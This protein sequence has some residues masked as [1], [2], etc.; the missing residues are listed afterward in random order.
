M[1][2][3]KV[4]IA[5]I[6][7]AHRLESCETVE[8][9]ERPR[10]G[11]Y[12]VIISDGYYDSVADKRVSNQCTKKISDSI[13]DGVRDS[14]SLRAASDHLYSLFLGRGTANVTLI[15]LDLNTETIVISRNNPHPIYCYRNEDIKEWSDD[16]EPMGS[17]THISPTI[18][19]IKIEPGTILIAATDGVYQAGSGTGSEW[20][21]P[22]Q[23][24]SILEEN[25]S[26]SAQDIADLILS[27]AIHLDENRPKQDM[28]VL[29]VQISSTAETTIP[30]VRKVHYQL[31]FG[32]NYLEDPDN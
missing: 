3:L 13:F 30:L 25:F 32:S 9:I 7:Q 5:K 28:T 1:M 29:V 6:A 24:I 22:L 21:I 23:L 17:T 10:G 19:E 14:V 11:G 26:P 18:N 20:D 16:S 15:S 27:Q 12:S 4:G 31:P 8:M 2:E